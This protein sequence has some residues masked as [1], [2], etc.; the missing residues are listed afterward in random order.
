MKLSN[1]AWYG[2]WIKILAVTQLDLKLLL[3]VQQHT[4][5]FISAVLDMVGTTVYVSLCFI[6]L[7]VIFVA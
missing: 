5:K 4:C 7:Y 3:K 2:P 6:I 1:C